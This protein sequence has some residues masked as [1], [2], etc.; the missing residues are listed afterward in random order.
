MNELLVELIND[1]SFDEVVVNYSY[2]YGVLMAVTKMY[3][4]DVRYVYNYF[5]KDDG[6][7]EKNNIIMNGELLNKNRVIHRI[8]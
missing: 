4:P 2:G 6:K 5:F 7:I 3:N 1:L 8:S